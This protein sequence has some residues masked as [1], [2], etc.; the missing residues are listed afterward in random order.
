MTVT[1]PPVTALPLPENRVPQ[2]RQAH[3]PVGHLALQQPSLVPPVTARVVAEGQAAGEVRDR[4]RDNRKRRRD[5][6]RGGLI[7]REF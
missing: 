4:N 2:H 3:T 6:G 5:P 1:L 7:D